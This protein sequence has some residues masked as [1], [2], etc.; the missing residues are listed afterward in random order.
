[1][2]NQCTYEIMYTFETRVCPCHEDFN[3][4]CSFFLA[5]VLPPCKTVTDTGKILVLD[6]DNSEFKQIAQDEPNNM[7]TKLNN[8]EVSGWNI[9]NFDYALL[10]TF[11]LTAN[12][13][14]H[15]VTS[16]FLYSIW[17]GI[18]KLNK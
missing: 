12:S 18:Q 5:V 15:H 2:Y 13:W 8:F 1:M 3:S 9:T 4:M 14:P 17:N 6:Q 16:S 11:S 7:K 10:M